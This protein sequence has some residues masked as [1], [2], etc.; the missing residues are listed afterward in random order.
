[1]G[2]N[3]EP[4]A[5]IAARNRSMEATAP[6]LV[7]VDPS[8][9][10]HEVAPGSDERHYLLAYKRGTLDIQMVDTSGGGDLSSDAAIVGTFRF[11][12]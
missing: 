11:H 9:F 10:D 1:M 7:G 6:L 4:S 2:S 12:T 5:G 3:R 8:S